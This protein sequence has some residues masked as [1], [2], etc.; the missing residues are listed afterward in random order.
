MLAA[1]KASILLR[2]AAL[3]DRADPLIVGYPGF[4]RLNMLP[5]SMR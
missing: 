2:R 4:L 1:K 3:I 5:L